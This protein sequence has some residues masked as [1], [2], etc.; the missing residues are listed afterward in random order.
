VV[1]V[2]LSVY[3][4]RS[5]RTL[6][7]APRKFR[8]DDDNNDDTSGE[9]AQEN[10]EA[11]MTQAIR[12]SRSWRQEKVVKVFH[13]LTVDLGHIGKV[14]RLSSYTYLVLFFLQRPKPH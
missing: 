9:N 12:R 13:F 2:P 3:L 6:A 8:A 1:V 14:Y 4:V 10:Y 7:F 5:V 11:A